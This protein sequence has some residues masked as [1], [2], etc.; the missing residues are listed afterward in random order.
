MEQAQCHIHY[1]LVP[2]LPV[3]SN[4]VISAFQPW[5]QAFPLVKVKTT[6]GSAYGHTYFFCLPTWLWGEIDP[7]YQYLT[8]PITWCFIN[9]VWHFL[10]CILYFVL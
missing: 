9:L 10:F 1:E 6:D 4:L 8:S 7:L 2:P 3:K 5:H